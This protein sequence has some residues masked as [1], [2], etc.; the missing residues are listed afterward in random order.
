MSIESV[1]IDHFNVPLP[2][3]LSDSTHGE[4]THFGLI[5]VR[6]RDSDGAEGGDRQGGADDGPAVK[7]EL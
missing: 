6:L 1:H 4:M 3:V 5:T 2:V 7:Q